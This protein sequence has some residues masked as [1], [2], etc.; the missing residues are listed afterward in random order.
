MPKPLVIAH[1]GDPS[2][3]LENSLAA[4]RLALSVPADMIEFDVRKSL[5]NGLFVMHDRET[6]RTAASNIDIERSATDDIARIRLM[7]GEPIPTLR[8]VLGLV[9]GKAGLNIEVKSRGA[10]G[11]VAA[12]L[13]FSRY[14]GQVLISSF[15]E[16]EVVD[17]RSVSPAVPVAGIFDTFIASEVLP[18]KTK[19][20]DIIS[21]NKSAASRELI[22]RFHHEGISVYVWTVDDQAEMEDLLAWGVDGIYSNKPGLLRSVVG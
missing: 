8:D 16:R 14:S 17:A 3:A 6:G 12:E 15:K 7:N 11:L 5:D 21:L 19:G 22:E 2:R 1:R 20:Y 9:R 4:F 10:G 18:Y 13:A